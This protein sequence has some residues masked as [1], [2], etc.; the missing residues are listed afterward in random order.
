MVSKYSIRTV[1]KNVEERPEPDF[2]ML[3]FM[4]LNVEMLTKY[5]L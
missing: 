4:S 3:D 1:Y 5:I 2:W